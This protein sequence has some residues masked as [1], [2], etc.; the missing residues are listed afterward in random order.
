MEATSRHNESRDS[1]ELMP[2]GER[3]D[4]TERNGS[5]DGSDNDHTSQNTV[6]D[7]DNSMEED[8]GDHLLEKDH[9]EQTPENPQQKASLSSAVTWMVVNTLATIGIVWSGSS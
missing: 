3:R 6:V 4:D 7:R 2:T 9:A 1:I 5:Y 8:E